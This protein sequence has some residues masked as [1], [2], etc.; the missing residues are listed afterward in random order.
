MHV[1]ILKAILAS[2]G[3]A[4]IEYCLMLPANRI[5]YQAGVPAFQLKMAQEIITWWYF[6]FL[7]LYI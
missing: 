6:Q 4:L 1:P 7:Q 5:G 3:I 2:W